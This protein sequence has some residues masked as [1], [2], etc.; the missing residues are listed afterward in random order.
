MKRFI[1]PGL[2]TLALFILIGCGGSTPTPV[3]PTATPTSEPTA[4]P[5]PTVEA[6]TEPTAE[7]T[8]EPTVAP[9]DTPV[10]EP[11]DLAATLAAIPELSRLS[12]A[13]EQAGLV[14]KLQSGGP[15]TLFAPTDAAFDALPAGALDNEDVLFD[16]LLYHMVAGELSPDDLAAQSSLTT[17]LGDELP[18]RMEGDVL[19]LGDD[20]VGQAAVTGDPIQATNGVIYMVDG[21]LIPESA[22]QP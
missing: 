19:H 13:I 21:V 15:F 16:V 18:L 8:P 1:L 6:T 7:P 4:T 5:E 11:V 2:L 10:P 9:T 20:A 17:L 22:G 3:P 14:E 12:A